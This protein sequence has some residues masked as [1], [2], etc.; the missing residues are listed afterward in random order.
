MTTA[1]I[2]QIRKTTPAKTTSEL[3]IESIR[4][5]KSS[6]LKSKKSA[7]AYLQSIGGVDKNGKVKVT[8]L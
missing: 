3:L 5:S 1:S 4:N 6:I 7:L 2:K 8:P